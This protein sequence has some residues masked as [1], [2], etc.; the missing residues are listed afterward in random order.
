MGPASSS[1]HARKCFKE[2]AGVLDEGLFVAEAIG[3][4]NPQTETQAYADS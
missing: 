2:I 1:G 3:L 4:R